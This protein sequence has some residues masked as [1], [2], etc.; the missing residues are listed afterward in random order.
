[1]APPRRTSLMLEIPCDP[2]DALWSASDDAIYGR[3]LDELRA[4]GFDVA[5]D[6]LGHFSSFV[7][8]GY[9]IYH[10]DYQRERQRVLEYCRDT[11]NVVSVG[12]Q[13]AFRYVFM[14]TAMEMGLA[15][16]EQLLGRAGAT[17]PSEIASEAGLI[18]AR[19][20]TA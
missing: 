5:R 2:G 20:L 7:E 11:S 16:A 19:A 3:C 6:V 4:L 13:G 10:L 1:M 15:A 8:E 12:R 18:E 14:D 9:P 17:P